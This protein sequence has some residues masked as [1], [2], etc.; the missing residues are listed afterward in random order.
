MPG[1]EPF[2]FLRSEANVEELC[3]ELRRVGL[4]CLA[5]RD[6]GLVCRCDWLDHPLEI[7][8]QLCWWP[9]GDRQEDERIA[10]M[11]AGALK[12]EVDVGALSAKNMSGLSSVS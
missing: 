11:Q 3:R 12:G 9:D 1:Q 5:V 8:W 6:D 4:D 2:R 10:I 7:I